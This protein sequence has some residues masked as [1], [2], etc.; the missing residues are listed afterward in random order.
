MTKCFNQRKEIKR[1]VNIKKY[2]ESHL[3]EIL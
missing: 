1:F 3:G 2:N